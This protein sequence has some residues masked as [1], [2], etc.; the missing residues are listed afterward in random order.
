[1]YHFNF[2]AEHINS[3][4]NK[5]LCNLFAEFFAVNDK[6]DLVV[7]VGSHFSDVCGNNRLTAAAPE[8]SANTP[9]PASHS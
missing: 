9:S 8:N 6:Q 4:R 2:A 5:R 3:A 1:L 7:I